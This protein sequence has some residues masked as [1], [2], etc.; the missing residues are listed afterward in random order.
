MD[1]R[2]FGVPMRAAFAGALARYRSRRPADEGSARTVQIPPELALILERHGERAICR[3]QNEFVCSTRKVEHWDSETSL[4][5]FAAHRRTRRTRTGVQH[6]RSS[7]SM[8]SEAVPLQSRTA[9]CRRCRASANHCQSCAAR[10]REHDEVAFLLGHRD[11]N[12]TRAAYLRELSD[13]RRRTMRRS[14]MIADFR[15]VLG[16][17][18]GD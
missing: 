17:D 13:A 4:A 9:C 8:T 2:T 10:R 15:D 18:D 16:A 1:E 5:R 3:S 7:T 6:S 12:V 11:A 14:R